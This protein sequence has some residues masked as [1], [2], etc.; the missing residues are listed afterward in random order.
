MDGPLGIGTEIKDVCV[1]LD[2]YQAPIGNWADKKVH[3][4]VV[5]IFPQQ[6]QG[7]LSGLLNPV[8]TETS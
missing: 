7:L 2:I 4:M 8:A 6:P 5:S 1:P 3:C